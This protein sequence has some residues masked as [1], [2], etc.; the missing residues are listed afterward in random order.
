MMCRVVILQD[1]E[2]MQFLCPTPDGDVGFT[3]YLLKAGMF[4]DDDEAKDTAE[5]MHVDQFQLFYCYV[6]LETKLSRRQ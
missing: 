3:P 4:E 1:L 2:N 5:M 6:D